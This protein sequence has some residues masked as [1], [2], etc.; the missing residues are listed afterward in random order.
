MIS[1]SDRYAS[2]H[3]HLSGPIILPV[4]IIP[5]VTKMRLKISKVLHGARDLLPAEQHAL[6]KPAVW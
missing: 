4:N 1:L 6:S 2:T 3:R 5:D